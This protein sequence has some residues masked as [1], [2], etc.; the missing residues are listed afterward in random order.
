M[1]MLLALDGWLP[2]DVS[3]LEN[4]RD[5]IHACDTIATEPPIEEEEMIEP[6]A[7]EEIPA[8]QPVN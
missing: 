4:S 3:K 1:I 7:V 2:D 5:V 8:A 6:E